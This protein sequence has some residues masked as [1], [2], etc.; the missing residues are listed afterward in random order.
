[1]NAVAVAA[2]DATAVVLVAMSM[3]ETRVLTAADVR[4]LLPMGECI[5][6]MTDALAALAD[7]RATV[8]NRASLPVDSLGGTL[9]LMPAT[10]R[11]IAESDGSWFG[12]KVLSIAP[13]NE[14]TGHPT[15]QGVLV[16]FEGEHGSPVAVI[17]A[18]AITAIRTAAVSAVATRILARADA[19]RLA[20]IGSG[21]QAWSHLVAMRV[22]RSI[23]DAIVW[24]RDRGRCETFARRAESELG[25]LVRVGTSARDTVEGADII[26]TVTSAIEPVVQS[27]WIGPGAHIN[28]I[29]TH[30][31][32][33]RELDSE[34][35]RR[36]RVFV[37]YMPA[38]MAEAGD[39]L[40]PIAESSIVRAHV[41]GDLPQLLGNRVRGRL[42]DTDVTVFKSVG[43]AVE[44]LAA[45]AHVYRRAI[46]SG[47]GIGV[48][49]A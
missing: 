43:I 8:P 1:L 12:A 41:I 37:D 23:R 31:P 11:G 47:A 32:A 7:G 42:A 2:V 34:T 17:D 22:I 4:A 28:S 26:C 27:A 45:A 30:R 20:I 38:A 25:I 49:L 21:V 44:D 24:S 19:S 29:G 15:H 36:A 6:V 33:D 10:I 14:S 35:V 48:T 39:M 3:T 46:A 16:L 18:G 5:D 40:V 13:R 9:L